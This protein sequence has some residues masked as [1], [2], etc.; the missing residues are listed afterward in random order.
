[1]SKFNTEAT[2][3]TTNRSGHAAYSM[4]D[5]DKLITQVLTSFF[6]EKK[7]YGDNSDDI[8]E[9]LKRVI[10]NDPEFVSKL[11][12]F[13]RREFNMRTI[14]HVMIGYLANI[15]EGKPYVKATVKGAILR[16]DDA[17]EIMSFYLNNFGKPIPNSLRKGLKEAL[18]K[19]DAYT[20]AKYKG[21]GKTVK[22]RDLLC[23]CRPTPKD[24]EQS[25]N[26]KKLLEGTLET[27]YTWE[28]ELSSKGNTKE[29]WEELIASGKVGYMALLR[30]LRNIITAGPSNLDACLKKIADPE[31]VAKSKQLPFRFLSAYQ[32]C[33]S[34]GAST[35]VYDAIEDAAEASIGNID[36][37]PGK[38]VIAID[39]SGSMVYGSISGNSDIRCRDIAMLFGVIANKLCEDAIV[40]KFDTSLKTVSWSHRGGIISTAL[41]ETANGG[42]TNMSLPFK[43]MIKNHIDCDRIIILSDN[44]CNSE[45][46]N[47]RLR[48]EDGGKVVQVL[49]D[50]YRSM[51][52][53]D[54]WVHAIDLQGYGTQQFAGKKVNIISGWSEKVFEFIHLVEQEEGTLKKAISEY[55]W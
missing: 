21:E 33:K 29:V 24:E 32:A 4:Q 7:F 11:A 9:T 47:W 40:V 26:F 12:V 31:A 55:T 22:M 27:P 28:T 13:A 49:A 6:N 14:S 45:S 15:P 8:I 43:Y 34:I 18:L 44:E 23:L 54:I 3:K 37:I 41:G 17:T 42:G 39:V 16:G 36:R 48:R 1:M 46:W 5:K 30:N 25:K 2:I 52:G 53:K 20:L 38:T 10:V 50:K 35:K 19:F 51:T